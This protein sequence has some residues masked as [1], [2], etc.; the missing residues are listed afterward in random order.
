M[1]TIPVIDAHQHFWQL[2]Q[3]LNYSWLDAPPLA[4][5]KR[6]F[7]PEHLGPHLRVAGVSHTVLVQTQHDLRENLWMLD[8]ADKHP[9]IAGVVGWVNLASPACEEQLGE[10]RRHPK[11]V[12]VRHLTQDEPDEQ[13]LLRD[14]VLHGLQVLERSGVPFDLLLHVK[15]LSHAATLARRFPAL[16]LVIDH[17]AKPYVKD[18]K[19][20]VWFTHLK[21]ASAYPNVSCKL[22][23]L[24]TEADWKNWTALD[25]KPYVQTA[26]GL[27]GPE[28]CMFGSDW[29]VCELAGTY[30]QVCAAMLEALEPLTNAERTAIFSGT[31]RRVYRL[32]LADT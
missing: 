10:M 27:F 6:D 9:F 26:L 19:T 3:P 16:P 32:R 8:L 22:S 24:V 28:R 7:L 17:L 5:I 14:D 21:E 13:F 30:E 20:E 29:P 18:H 15:H 11:F 1:E 2:S 12:G 25:L 4:A 31:A 23:G